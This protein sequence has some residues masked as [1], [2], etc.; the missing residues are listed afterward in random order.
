MEIG[1]LARIRVLVSD[2]DGVMTDGTIVVGEGG[3]TKGFNVRDGLGIKLLQRAGLEFA[4][5]SG[6]SS[7][8]V[9][10]RSRDLGIRIVKVGRI[11]KETAFW[12]I[13]RELGVQPEEM[14]YIG[15]DIIDIAPLTLAAAGFCPKDAV[16]EVIAIADHVLS[17]PGGGGAVRQVAEMILKAQGHWSKIVASFGVKRD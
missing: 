5:L 6:R 8:P 15:D 14:A 16:P 17:V 2:V 11:D 10:Q 7:E 9:R 13:A 3:E 1:T 4:I 12:E